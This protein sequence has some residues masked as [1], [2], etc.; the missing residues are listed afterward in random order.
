MYEDIFLDVPAA[1]QALGHHHGDE[2]FQ[3]K[4]EEKHWM[5]TPG[6]IYCGDTVSCGTG[7][8]AAPN[9]VGVDEKWH[10]VIYRQ[11]ANYNE[12]RQVVHAA[13]AEVVSGYGADGDLHWSYETIKEW[14][15]EPR[16]KVEQEVRRLYEAELARNNKTSSYGCEWKWW[17][18]YL[19]SGMHQYL[20]VYAFFL[21]NGRIPTE[22]DTLP[23]F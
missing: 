21:D 5:N 12:L 2:Y 23:E 3:G 10:E 15:A 17:L 13:E 18:G 4:W 22:R 7:P 14:W 20:Q 6:P 1:L 8:P 16:R 19:K 11:P 9:N